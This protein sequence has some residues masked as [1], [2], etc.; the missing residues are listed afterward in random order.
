MSS[1]ILTT[2]GTSLLG[3]AKREGLE[4]EKAVLAYLERSPHA[5][6]AETNSLLGIWQKGDEVVLL[7]SDTEEGRRCAE[8]IA[9]FWKSKGACS[10]V[11]IEGLT[12]EA[13]GF[14]DYGLKHFVQTL[15][16]EIRNAARAQKEVIINATGGF[17]AE[18][19]YATALGLVFKVPV[20]YMHERFREVVMLPPS[21]FGWDNS[22]LAWHGNFFDWIDVE[23][24]STAEVRGRAA[25]LPSEVGLLLEDTPDGYT[26]LSP[27]GQAYLEAFRAELEQAQTLS[28]Y[29]SK[30]AHRAWEGFDP[31]TQS[32]FRQVLERLRLPNRASQSEQKSGGG[33]GLGYPKGHTAERIFYTEED[34][35]LYVFEL[36]RHGAGY[37][38]L[39]TKGVRWRDHPKEEFTQWEG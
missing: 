27:L 39:C 25:T 9:H 33:D 26:M 31:T 8:L 15:A 3:N 23:P 30:K 4:D 13:Q 11:R 14:V 28:V 36:T 18:I 34:G 10:Q 29:L 7:H 24:R 37:E 5:A 21:P 22:L 1:V 20:C 6:C 2:V 38:E 19:A 32:Q 12:Y 17:K 16:G 35:G